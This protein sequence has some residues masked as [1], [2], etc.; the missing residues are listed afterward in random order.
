MESTNTFSNKC[1]TKSSL[2]RLLKK[3]GDIG[4]VTKLTDSGEPSA[5]KN[6]HLVNDLVVSQEDTPQT[7]R[8]V[9]ENLIIR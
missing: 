9:H 8:T 3:F 6:V 5:L 2:N 4:A 1:W 7:H